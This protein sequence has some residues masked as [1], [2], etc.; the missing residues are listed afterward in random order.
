MNF[1]GLLEYAG[2]LREVVFSCL[3]YCEYTIVYLP[4]NLCNNIY[5][6]MYVIFVCLYK[7][8]K[9]IDK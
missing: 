7:L 3:L 8:V 2:M 4:L 6:C 5:I 1:F 9:K